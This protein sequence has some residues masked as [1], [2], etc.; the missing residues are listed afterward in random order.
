[1]IYFY[2]IY[3]FRI[4]AKHK[5]FLQS[6]L[7]L[8]FL[9]NGFTKPKYLYLNGHWFSKFLFLK[10]NKSNGIRFYDLD[11]KYLLNSSNCSGDSLTLFNYKSRQNRMSPIKQEAK[12][13]CLE[14]WTSF[15]WNLIKYQFKNVFGLMRDKYNLLYANMSSFYC[16]KFILCVHLERIKIDLTT[17]HSGFIISKD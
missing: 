7:K 6:Y 11:K 13:I 14:N 3:V 2:K 15:F 4:S 16:K 12:K 8:K 5:L 9:K 1:M 17:T 10:L